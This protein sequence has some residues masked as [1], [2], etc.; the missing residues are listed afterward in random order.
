MIYIYICSSVN[1]CAWKK[2]ESPK[3]L[4]WVLQQV[5]GLVWEKPMQCCRVLDYSTQ[6]CSFSWY[7]F[8]VWLFKLFRSEGLF[9]VFLVSFVPTLIYSTC[10]TRQV[11]QRF[12]NTSWLAWGRYNSLYFAYCVD[13]RYQT[14]HGHTAWLTMAVSLFLQYEHHSAE[15]A[16]CIVTWIERVDSVFSSV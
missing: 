1:A 5:S 10:S 16:K 8:A 7:R 12:S 15:D 9:S 2:L 3:K 14:K 6:Y 13:H 11:W 4:L